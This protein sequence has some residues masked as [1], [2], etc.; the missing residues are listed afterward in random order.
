[1]PDTGVA[2]VARAT[3]DKLAIV[4]RDL[5][6]TFADLDRRAN[7]VA[8]AFARR[9]VTSGARVSIALRNRGEFFEAAIGAA[10][11]GAE[12]VP[13]S[14]RSKEDEMRFMIEDSSSAVVVAEADAPLRDERMLVLGSSYD[15]ARDA[16]P[17]DPVTNDAAPVIFRYYTSGTTGRPK[18][19][20]RA[21][22]D[23]A[24][25]AQGVRAYVARFGVEG[26][27]NVHLACGPLY[28]TAPCAFANYAL[29]LGQ[30]V[31]LMER[32]DAAEALRVIEHER[33]TWSHMVPIN[34]VRILGLDEVRADLSSIRRI[35]HAAAPCPVEI[36][37]RIMSLFPPGAVWE[38]YGMTEGLA[39][40]IS[41][42]EWEAKPGSVG[43]AAPGIELRVFDDDGR[44]CAPGETGTVYVSPTGGARFRYAGDDQ[45]TAAAWRGDLFTVGDMGY[46]D[47]DGYLFL[48][49]RKQD[50]IITGGAN[51]YPAEV[52]AVLFSHPGVADVAVVGEP[53][54]EWG[55]RVRAIVQPRGAV[56]EAEL[57]EFCTQ[58]LASYKC[59]RHIEI[60]AAL[61]RDDNGKVRKREIRD[62]L[63]GGTPRRI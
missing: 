40:I 51:V 39:T 27:D 23:R 8:R 55:E 61:P 45:K 10:R 50:L 52:E 25:Y 37:R 46:L 1:M 42:Q 35:L 44:V 43:R 15:Q 34:F 54:E 31:V 32:F 2:N 28:H 53:D 36:K 17:P 11:C 48:T 38:Y 47:A 4:A 57:M 58:N 18:A 14:W 16:E 30:T 5:R 21:N 12:V 7:R 22:V 41:A 33:V 6:W 60:V 62:R 59:P 13:V 24:G 56:T 3:P 9:G 19:V 26:A 20:E 63:W 29:L 49:D